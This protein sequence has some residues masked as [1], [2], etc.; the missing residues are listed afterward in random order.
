MIRPIQVTDLCLVESDHFW[1]TYTLI[2]D[3]SR[4]NR[5]TLADVHSSSLE[6]STPT[7]K[8]LF[9]RS[10]NTTLEICLPCR[11]NRPGRAGLYPAD[12]RCLVE[13]PI[14]GT[15]QTCKMH[16]ERICNRCLT[17]STYLRMGRNGPDTPS[18]EQF[19]TNLKI[20]GSQ[21]TDEYDLK[22]NET[23]TCAACREYAVLA[24]VDR[25]LTSCARN[26]YK[27][28]T[29]LRS[30]INSLHASVPYIE[31]GVG[32]A[33]ATAMMV[34][35]EVWL[36]HFSRWDELVHVA[37]RLQSLEYAYFERMK[38]T[39]YVEYPTERAHRHALLVELWGDDWLDQTHLH[40]A[41]VELKNLFT[42][43]AREI[44][45]TGGFGIRHDD[46]EITPPQV[47]TQRVSTQTSIRG[48]HC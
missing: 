30:V 22:R 28:R 14:L 10:R 39:G 9:H 23:V 48:T 31:D 43:W 11:V 5:S 20:T 4:H 16:H 1:D 41:D 8:T 12:S 33:K 24:H 6:P 46:A 7:H 34:V 2:L 44:A 36:H 15:L 35:E 19:R 25:I 13:T 21:D 45:A 17:E 32:T 3:N 38:R 42:A 40:N 18:T 29:S 27:V 47:L 26:S 37:H